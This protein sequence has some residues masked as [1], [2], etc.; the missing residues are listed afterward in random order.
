[1]HTSSRQ[2]CRSRLRCLA[3]RRGQGRTGQGAQARIPTVGAQE[4]ARAVS[5]SPTTWGTLGRNTSLSV[6]L[7]LAREWRRPEP[8]L[9]E[10]KEAKATRRA[11]QRLI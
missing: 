6:K 2:R 3:L 9:G 1:M 4:P 7:S 10:E 11:Q 5:S 8:R